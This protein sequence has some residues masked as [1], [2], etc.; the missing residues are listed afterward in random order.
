MERVDDATGSVVLLIPQTGQR[1]T[2]TSSAA[3]YASVCQP[4]QAAASASS[5]QQQER[6]SRQASSANLLSRIRRR[7][8]YARA[9]TM[10]A[11][12]VAAAAGPDLS[13]EPQ[14]S[15]SREVPQAQQSEAVGE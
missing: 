15:T 7:D 11:A 6:V 10:A 5:S 4:Q 2:L 13:T 12:A 8:S 14:P 9:E 1:F 3:Q